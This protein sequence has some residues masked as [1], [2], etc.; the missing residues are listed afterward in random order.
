MKLLLFAHVETLLK[1]VQQLKESR[2]AST[3][4]INAIHSSQERRKLW[5]QAEQLKNS[6]KNIILTNLKT[7]SW[8]FLLTKIICVLKLKYGKKKET[9]I[10]H[11]RADS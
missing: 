4:A 8:S 6:R 3:F 10:F 9:K 5:T 1:H 11:E 2:S 7:P